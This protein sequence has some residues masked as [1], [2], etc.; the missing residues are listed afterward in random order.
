MFPNDMLF[1]VFGMLV[2]M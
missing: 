2:R 1:L